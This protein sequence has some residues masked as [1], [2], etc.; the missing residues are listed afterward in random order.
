MVALIWGPDA[1][2]AKARKML[3]EFEGFASAVFPL[4]A[5]AQPVVDFGKPTLLN[6]LGRN[7]RR[8]VRDKLTNPQ[9]AFISR[10]ELGLY[11]LL[12]QLGARVNTREVWR[13]V[14]GR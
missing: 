3:E 2:V 14:A 5:A 10:A 7:L 13:C 9:F 1:P 8:A 6:A 11:N 12:H 4:P